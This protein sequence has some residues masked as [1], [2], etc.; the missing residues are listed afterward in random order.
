MFSLLPTIYPQDVVDFIIRNYF[1]FLDDI[2]FQWLKNFD[3][4]HFYKIFEDLDEDLQFIFA[5]L[6]TNMNFLDIDFKIVDNQ[7][8]LNLYHKPTDSYNY[9]NYTS[10]HPQHTKDNIALSL[11]KRI[12][13]I[14][15]DNREEPLD[16]LKKH[17]NY[18]F[19]KVFQPRSKAPRCHCI[20]DYV[21]SEAQIQ[22]QGYQG[23]NFQSAFPK[24]E[25]G[26]WG[27]HSCHGDS[28]TRF[29]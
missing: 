14:V 23:Y 15:S 10:A 9:L 12:V 28:T 21:Q 22:P 17:L 25:A 18:A 26:F 13:R 8:I 3:V 24:D 4:T 11:A 19:S 20:H 7:L 5:N 1:R 29:S 16:A 6:S 2:F 27:Y